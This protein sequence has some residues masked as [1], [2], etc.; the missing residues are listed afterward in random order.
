MN[1]ASVATETD[2]KSIFILEKFSLYDGRPNFTVCC[3]RIAKK[4]M[5]SAAPSYSLSPLPPGPDALASWGALCALSFAHRPGDPRRFAARWLIDGAAG[6]G[7]ARGAA[8][9]R[10]LTRLALDGAGALAGAVRVYVRT[11]LLPRAGATALAGLGDVCTHPAQRGRGVAAL[12]LPDALAAGAAALAAGAAPAPAAAGGGLAALHAAPTVGPLYARHGFAYLP[13]VPYGELRAPALQPP[14]PPPRGLRA[15]RLP[16]SALAAPASALWRRL[17][18]LHAALCAAARVAG[19]TLRDEDYWRR[20]VPFAVTDRLVVFSR[21]G[22]GEEDDSAIVAYAAFV[23]KSEHYRLADAGAAAELL[24]GA[25]PGA[26]RACLAAAAAEAMAA[27][28]PGSEWHAPPAPEPAVGAPL[29]AAWRA[30]PRGGGAAAGLPP[31]LPVI[32]VP[33]AVLRVDPAAAGADESEDVAELGDGGW[34]AR[35]L[36]TG[37]EA[38]HAELLAAAES[39]DLLI[40]LADAF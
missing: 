29:L 17:D 27:A 39:G 3:K 6:E 33:T 30:A 23:W 15:R 5:S 11:W 16:A 31:P 37:G 26:L 9:R 35:T 32:A 36:G 28:P 22:A 40:W 24:G 14:P 13:R 12:L 7:G 38:A 25:A 2:E 20:W 18:A 10:A 8:S 21:E 4:R 34:M 19:A 1:V